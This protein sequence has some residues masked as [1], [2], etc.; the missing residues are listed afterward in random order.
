[1]LPSRA[2]VISA[3]FSNPFV[4]DFAFHPGLGHTTLRPGHRPG[5]P[6]PEDTLPGAGTVHSEGPAAAEGAELQTKSLRKDACQ[7]LCSRSASL[8]TVPAH[9]RN[10]WLRLTWTPEA[11]LLC[12]PSSADRCKWQHTDWCQLTLKSQISRNPRHAVC[13]S[14]QVGR[15]PTVPPPLGGHA[16]VP[17]R[18]LPVLMGPGSPKAT[19]CSL[20]STA[21][22]SAGR[23]HGQVGRSGTSLFPVSSLNTGARVHFSGAATLP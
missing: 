2:L 1:M 11:L 20:R 14:V 19:L 3:L 13:P 18:P 10:A 8:R 6:G 16:G 17:A 22:T 23:A 15:V 4:T 21:H 12:C 5:H 7:T 9:R